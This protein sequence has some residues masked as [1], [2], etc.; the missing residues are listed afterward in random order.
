M[1]RLCNSYQNCRRC[2]WPLLRL[3][4]SNKMHAPAP[5]H[6]H[7]LIENEERGAKKAGNVCKKCTSSVWRWTIF[8]VYTRKYKW[9]A[10]LRPIFERKKN[11]RKKTVN[12][13]RE[14]TRDEWWQGKNR[15]SIGSRFDSTLTDERAS[16]T[17]FHVCS[18][19]SVKVNGDAIESGLGPADVI[20]AI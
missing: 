2:Y 15:K 18:V 20:I 13:W 11:R 19:S 7:Y 5:Y 8:G 9:Q 6:T 4:A 10:C 12:L 3:L 16:A 14:S 17:H 1:N